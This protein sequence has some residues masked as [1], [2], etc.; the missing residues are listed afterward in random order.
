MKR[1]LKIDFPPDTALIHPDS[2][3]GDE[4]G[5]CNADEENCP[6]GEAH[7]HEISVCKLKQNLFNVSVLQFIKN[8]RDLSELVR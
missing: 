8:R 1:F 6:A 2:R 3:P 5:D 4:G 7:V